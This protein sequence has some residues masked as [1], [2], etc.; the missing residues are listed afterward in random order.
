MF[1]DRPETPMGDPL[2]TRTTEL[3]LEP[4]SCFLVKASRSNYC[5]NDYTVILSRDRGL[6]FVFKGGVSTSTSSSLLFLFV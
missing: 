1:F 3:S 4:R 2:E 6:I 5:V